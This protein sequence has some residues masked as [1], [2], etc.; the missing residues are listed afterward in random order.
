MLGLIVQDITTMKQFYQEVLGFV[1]KLEMDHFVE[2]D[3]E[4]IRFALS[5]ASVMH[6]ATG[7]SSFL[8]EKKGHSVELAFRCADMDEVKQTYHTLIE[9]GATPIKEAEEMPWGQCTAF[10]ADPEGN[11]H[12]LFADL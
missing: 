7:E 6:Q 10:F 3:H 9:K 11:I 4:G 8:E 12:E 1:P 5:T 2:F